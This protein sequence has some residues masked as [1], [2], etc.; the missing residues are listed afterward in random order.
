[1]GIKQKVQILF[2]VFS[3]LSG[4]GKVSGNLGWLYERALI[5]S[6]AEFSGLVRT[7][8][9]EAQSTILILT[10]L[11]RTNPKQRAILSAVECPQNTW[12]AGPR[13]SHLP[14]EGVCTS[15]QQQGEK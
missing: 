5:V 4:L 15:Q 11:G 14:R 8:S 9:Y 12:I 1:M 2:T 10:F 6:K 13:R 3:S 7:V